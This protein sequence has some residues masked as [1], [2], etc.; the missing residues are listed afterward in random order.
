MRFRDEPADGTDAAADRFADSPIDR[1]QFVRLSAAT[2]GALALPGNATASV[3]SSEMDAEY[4][5][6][7][8]HTAADHA[9]PTLVT[10]SSASGPDAMDA[11]VDAGT[12]TTTTPEPAAHAGL[13][14]AQ[15]GAVADLP[16]AE[17]I[18]YAPG[19]NPF[20]RLGYYPLGVFPAP[21]RSTGYVVYEEMIAGMEHLHAEN[22]DRMDFYSI[23]ESPGHPN[24]LTDREDPKEVWG[25]E[26]TNDID[27]EA[28]YQEK[29][30][31]LFSLSI[32]G[33][34]RAGAEAGCRFIENLFAGREREVEALLD[35]LVLLFVFSN[36]DGWVA[37][38]P[39]YEGRFSRQNAAD[40]DLNRQFPQ[41]GWIDPT[42]FPAEPRGA[43]AED[44][45]PGIDGDVP[46]A[47]RET[48]PD[49]LSIVEHFR[50][51]ENL[52]YAGDFH[53]KSV[54]PGNFVLGLISQD[55]FDHRALHELYA[56]NR[57]VDE[58]LTGELDPRPYTQ[59]VYDYSTIW[60]TLGYTV[61]GAMGD[62]FAYPESLGGLGTTSMDFEMAFANFVASN[63]Y[64]PNLVDKQVTGY[65][66]GIRTFAEIAVQNSDTPNTTDEFASSVE[67]GGL[68]TA[69][70]TT[71][72]LTRSSEGLNLLDPAALEVLQETDYSGVLG[73]G[74]PGTTRQTHTFTAP[75]GSLRVK[76]TLSWT[77]NTQDIDFFLEDE[78]GDRVASSATFG[79]PEQFSTPIEAGTE[80]TYVVES[81]VNVAA[82]YEIDGE[83]TG[84]GDGSGDG[85]DGS[86]TTDANATFVD[87]GTGF[88]QGEETLSL[89]GGT[90][91]ATVAVPD[92]T[93]TLSASLD[94]DGPV[95]AALRDPSG[96]T[97][98]S[99]EPDGP[100]VD[101][102]RVEWTVREP[103][104]GTWTIA[105]TAS[106]VESD[107]LGASATGD[108]VV[109]TTTTMQTAETEF[110]PSPAAVLGYEQFDYKVSPFVFFDEE[111]IPSDDPLRSLTVERDFSAFADAD[112]DPLTVEEVKGD[113]HL[114]YDNLV[115]IHDDGATDGAYLDA[116][117]RF[118]DG[119]GNLVLT[120][121]GVNL[122][123]WMDSDVTAGIT[124]EDTGRETFYV[125]HLG[126]KNTDHPLLEDTRSIQNQLWKIAGLG[127]STGDEAPMTLVAGE[128]FDAAGG[129]PAG[130]QTENRV[131]AGTL[132]ADA[133]EAAGS[134]TRELAA[135]DSGS[136]HFIGGLFP[137]ASQA[138]LHPLGL[139][140]YSTSF[141]GHLMFTHALGYVQTRSVGEEAPTVFGGEAT[142][143]AMAP[144]VSVSGTREDSGRAFTAGEDDRI[145]L[146]VTASEPVEVRD[147]VPIEW[148]VVRP[149]P[150]IERVERDTE[151]GI[152]R[153]YFNPESPT[154]SF[155]VTYLAEAPS[156]VGTE[157]RTGTYE[158]GPIEASVDGQS[159]TP[160]PD[161]TDTNVVLA[162]DTRVTD[163]TADGT[164][165]AGDD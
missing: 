90:D 132:I 92:G 45:E 148:T 91:A 159:W 50:D 84:F 140:D 70:V 72:A 145:D 73:P 141:L 154:E 53:G 107:A 33:D 47:I 23:G 108:E 68:R 79:G 16:T 41:V 15:A 12:V 137:P 103:D 112:V 97:V 52:N 42:H 78:S 128:A 75:E 32:H 31:V 51:Y 105:A 134:T 164:G 144:E 127:Y 56:L 151:N 71:E 9:V 126:E 43:D 142:F 119:G 133:S 123:G 117:D 48:V 121:A 87:A 81:F 44:D 61:S 34:E 165:G 10:F 100:V 38:H 155:E 28:S 67:T 113:A 77:A 86:S 139:L 66:Q 20:W 161:T 115:V 59:S 135:S 130:V 101:G 102:A 88:D 111:Y 146:S 11:A 138:N 2:A 118:V 99:R 7:R 96:E 156:G 125:A 3:S 40:V 65:V 17:T 93:H 85:S 120:D 149:N 163:D 80:Y 5:Y 14:A 94:P 57:T 98:R 46:P 6:V 54:F 30:K 55:Q 37:R 18:T 114:A 24:L 106:T 160:V 116:V 162:R 89:S 136:V 131:S 104:A 95:A 153:L 157:V 82:D 1:R 49:A 129:R 19:A 109:V 25:V 158:F 62:W 64:D 147:L 60:D 83:V 27:D 58:T 69:Y 152:K 4:E 13:T 124:P 122:V 74:G 36:P 39:Q 150:V 29:E 63:Y 21:T 35:D 76:A 22:D 26:V 143:E 110:S 8:N